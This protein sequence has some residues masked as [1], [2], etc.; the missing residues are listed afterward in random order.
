MIV[1]VLMGD[2][3]FFSRGFHYCGSLDKRMSPSLVVVCISQSVCSV[4]IRGVLAK[5]Y[6]NTAKIEGLSSER[7]W[8][9]L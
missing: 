9:Y 8:K 3:S 2:W 6:K 5:S 1:V 7:G 4:L